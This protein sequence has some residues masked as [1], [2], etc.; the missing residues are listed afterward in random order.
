MTRASGVDRFGRGGRSGRQWA[1]SET[2]R[3]RVSRRAL[4]AGTALGAV[5]AATISG[6]PESEGASSVQRRTI[7]VAPFTVQ[8]PQSALDDLRARLAAPRWPD[9]IPG[10][11]WSLGTDLGY[12]RGLVGYW[13][14]GFDW[15]AQE[16][17]INR[18]AHRRAEVDGVGIHFIQERGR[19]PAPLPLLVTH[20]W[21]SSFLEM[22]ELIPLL[23]D[24]GAHG[25]DPVD[26]FDVVVPS[27]P[28]FGFSDR[29]RRPGTTEAR[30]ADLWARLMTDA[31]GYRRFAA[32]GGDVGAAVTQFL[33]AAHA[34]RLV[35][36]HLIQDADWGPTEG[37][38]AF[39][40]ATKPQTLA[41]GLND[42]P[43]GLAAWLVEKFRTWSDSGGDVER[44]F[45]KD[46]LLANVTLYWVTETIGSS[47]R[48][49][50][51]GG[52]A[53]AAWGD[54]GPRVEVPAGVA[55]VGWSGGPPPAE[56][57]ARALADLR[58]AT[59]MPSGGHFLAGEE[60]AL[61]ADE[62]RAFFR[63]LR[64]GSTG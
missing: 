35:G 36:I 37:A 20:G 24:P 25:G 56:P 46:D 33:G 53:G 34:D 50:A 52:G 12:L 1:T 62:L 4:L 51:A 49:Y 60:P 9:E 28:G 40:Q 61:L 11:G 59:P 6:A 27:L 41:Y 55:L 13:R 18:F 30:I 16:A 22:L 29:P 44:R 57:D 8:V 48:L 31:L 43:V 14:D 17:R 39:L 23:T 38:Y 10:T 3:T 15:R 45:A 5:A 64:S 32:H 42:S 58:R 26:A 19:G 63:P 7:A 54:P 21:P 47:V 2:D